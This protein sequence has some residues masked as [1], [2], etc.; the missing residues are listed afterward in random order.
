[1]IKAVFLATVLFLGGCALNPTQQ[2]LAEVGV[3]FATMEIINKETAEEQP[4]K[5]ARI[6]AGAEVALESL[7]TDEIVVIDAVELAVRAAIP[8]DELT[9][10]RK[11]QANL[12]IDLVAD[13]IKDQIDSGEVSG[14]ALVSARGIVEAIIEATEF[15]L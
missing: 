8:W 4:I 13:I 15:Y 5:A 6:K 14:D 3:G 10:T 12:F 7:T 9:P 11:I 1:M 2:T